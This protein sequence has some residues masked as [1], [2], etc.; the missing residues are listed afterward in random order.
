MQSS[1]ATIAARFDE[2][3]AN[4][5]IRPVGWLLRFLLQP[6]GAVR[7]G[8]SDR[9]TARCAAV[10]TAPSATRDRLLP[11]LFHPPA[12]EQHNG[13][14]RLERAFALLAAAQP[15]RDRMQAARVRD[16]DQ[17]LKQRTINDDEAAQLKE[18][19]EAV[20]A[21]VAVD[22]FAPEELTGRGASHEGDVPS[23]TFQGSP[24]AADEVPLRFPPAA[25]E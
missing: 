17:A 4:F 21:A 18:A 8:P 9:L 25:A 16:I 7:R 10:L 14:A 15:I 6:F 13:V 1:F 23:A 24:A 2:I 5:P 11:D 3:F 22:D 20:A 12:S 19:A